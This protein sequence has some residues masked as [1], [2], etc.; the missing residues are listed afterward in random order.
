MP[1]QTQASNAAPLARE[2]LSWFSQNGGC[3]SSDVQLVHDDSHGFHMVATGPLSSP[4]VV[5]CPLKLTLSVLN[6]DPVR[7][8]VLSVDS[9]LQLCRGKIPDHTL[10]YLLLINQRNL[11]EASPWYA[12]IACLPGPASM[13]T[14]LWFDDDDLKF[15]A[16][17]SVAPAAQE[18]K[19]DI[20]RQWDNA[21]AVFEDLKI[22]IAGNVNV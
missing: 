12:Y 6:L 21:V 2:L 11:G 13:T 9:Q 7:E 16:G 20:V 15:L 3:V 17:T 18:R 1:T 10:S 14:P 8:E 22:S 19:Q 5:S 4:V